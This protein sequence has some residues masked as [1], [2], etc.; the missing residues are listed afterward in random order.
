MES[1]NEDP[2]NDY[3]KSIDP[4][5]LNEYNLRILDFLIKDYQETQRLN[6]DLEIRLEKNMRTQK[7]I[8]LTFFIFFII[9]QL[10]MMYNSTNPFSVDKLIFLFI[11]LALAVFVWSRKIGP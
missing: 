4:D 3:I 10:N 5:A 2:L 9:F 1:A 6:L 11:F 7:K 8:M